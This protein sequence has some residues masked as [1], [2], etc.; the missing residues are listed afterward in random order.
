[1]EGFVARTPKPIFV[2]LPPFAGDKEREVVLA[3]A[4]IAQ[5]AGAAGLTCSNSRPVTDPK[6]VVGGGG[7][8]GRALWPATPSIVSA[9]AEATGHELV[10]NACGGVFSAQDALQCLQSGATTVQIYTGLIYE[11]PGVLGRMAKGLA[12][13]IGRGEIVLPSA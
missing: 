9:V 2:K 1:V 3:L 7:L 11:G 12:A 10:L 4:R 8:S 13:K 6:L 5:D